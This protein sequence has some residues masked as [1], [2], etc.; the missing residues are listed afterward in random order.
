MI[1]N[2]KKCVEHRASSICFTCP[3]CDNCIRDAATAYAK[4]VTN[5]LMPEVSES[6]GID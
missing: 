5:D 2:S 3:N 6:K 4:L 1:K